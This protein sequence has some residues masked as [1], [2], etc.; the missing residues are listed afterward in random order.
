MAAEITNIIAE[1]FDETDVPDALTAYHA[2]IESTTKPDTLVQIRTSLGNA[3]GSTHLSVEDLQ[4]RAEKTIEKFTEAGA[5]EHVDG[6][7]SHF[8]YREDEVY[9]A[10]GG[11]NRIDVDYDVISEHFGNLRSLV[12]VWN[13]ATGGKELDW[14]FTE[15]NVNSKSYYD[16]NDPDWAEHTNYGMKQIAPP[17]LEMF[18]AMVA[19]GVD[20]A[21]IWSARNHATSV[22][23]QNH[24]GD[25]QL[26]IAGH[27]MKALQE[28]TVGKEYIELGV[29][30]PPNYDAHFFADADDGGVLFLSSRTVSDPSTPQEIDVDLW[31]LGV[32]VDTV[33]VTIGKPDTGKMDGKFTVANLGFFD[34]VPSYL[35]PDVGLLW[36]T[37]TV[38]VVNGVVQIDL[39][40]TKSPM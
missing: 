9:D 7:I 37:V 5:L 14:H 25:T 38:P 17:L 21:Q 29:Q 35:E 26:Q 31:S 28:Q 39:A 6:V 36:T 22:G 8:Y 32:N 23:L 18:S 10:D 4:D 16:K 3:A 12:D 11:A 24:N 19:N 2:A 34:N 1:Y 20:A 40:P 30:D 33:Q 13:V 27:L 15:W